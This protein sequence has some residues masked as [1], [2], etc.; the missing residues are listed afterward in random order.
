VQDNDRVYGVQPVDAGM[1]LR[2]AQ[3]LSQV[4]D[5]RGQDRHHRQRCECAGDCGD[6][7]TA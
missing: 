4:R 5:Q 3:A 7:A 1:V 6:R 2:Q